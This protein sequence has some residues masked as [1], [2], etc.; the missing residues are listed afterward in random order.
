MHTIIGINGNIG[1]LLAQELISK[2][3]K[4]RGVSRQLQEGHQWESKTADVLDAQSLKQ[5][6]AGSEVVYLLVGLEY[7]TA[8]WKRDWVKLMQ[9]TIDACVATDAKL[10]FVD[11]VYMYGYVEGEMTE[12]TPIHPCS[13]K[14][15][16]RAAVAQ[17]LI[18]AF[19]HHRL[20]GCIARAAD[21]YG[22]D[23]STSMLTQTIFLNMAK[24]K[25]A[26]LMGNMDAIHSYTYT[27]DIAKALVIMATDSRADNQVW[28]LPTAKN[29][30]SSR[31]IVYKMAQLMGKSPKITHMG[32][33]MMSI[34]GLFIPILKELKE[35]MY[36]Y[37]K[38]YVFN[39]DKFDSTFGFTPTSY[40]EGLMTCKKFYSN[41]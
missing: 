8:V 25:A 1:R 23:C 20:R 13:E 37:D 30:L 14:G 2:G 7:K 39:S 35:M 22:P 18:D 34:L 15:K 28:H 3:Y 5:A 6:V 12:S 4:V 32:K 24:N 27:P 29:P 21:F 17:L 10:I 41:V 9:N 31:Q 40:E 33:F 19:D 36:Q 26:Q 11:N 38:N 16:V